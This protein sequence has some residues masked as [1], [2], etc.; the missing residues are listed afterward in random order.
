M[1]QI[2]YFGLVSNIQDFGDLSDVCGEV[3]VSTISGQELKFVVT[4]SEPVLVLMAYL[5]QDTGVPIR[6]QRST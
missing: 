3:K 2:V 5:H 4:F 6:K 1:K